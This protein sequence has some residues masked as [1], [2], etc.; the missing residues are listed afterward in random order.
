MRS[1]DILK[2]LCAG[3]LPA[4]NQKLNRLEAEVRELKAAL[5]G[6]PQRAGRKPRVV[7]NGYAPAS[8]DSWEKVNSLRPHVASLKA[9]SRMLKMPYSTVRRY[10]AMPE[11]EAFALRAKEDDSISE[12]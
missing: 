11:A 9:I 6:A 5:A 1:E 2:Q 3:V 7:Q 10:S 8:Y 4:L 12:G